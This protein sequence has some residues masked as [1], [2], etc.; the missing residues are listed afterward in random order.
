MNRD[1]LKT[2]I[3]DLDCE[4]VERGCYDGGSG[5]HGTDLFVKR[6]SDGLF[7]SEEG[8]FNH[9]KPQ[10]QTFNISINGYIHDQK[11][12]DDGYEYARKAMNGM[13]D[14]LVKKQKVN[15]YKGCL[16]KIKKR[17]TKEELDELDFEFEQ[18][19]ELV[20]KFDDET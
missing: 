4:L 17:L 11:T 18:L 8:L 15:L 7:L 12:Y 19:L 2:L 14:N 20:E 1:L 16:L 9:D 5:W 3:S 10:W 13:A 6:N